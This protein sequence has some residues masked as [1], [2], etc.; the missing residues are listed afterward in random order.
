M[1]NFGRLATGIQC[2]ERLMLK[3]LRLNGTPDGMDLLSFA[4]QRHGY[5]LDTIELFLRASIND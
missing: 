4:M 5:R 3:S 2:E 1:S